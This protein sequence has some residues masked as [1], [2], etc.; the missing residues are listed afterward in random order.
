M[1][2]L[3]FSDGKKLQVTS[4][5]NGDVCI[6]LFGK[7]GKQAE[8]VSMVRKDWEAIAG[9]VENSSVCLGSHA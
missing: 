4:Y 2:C 8:S 5:A 6:E 3:T 9:F 1:K 7:D